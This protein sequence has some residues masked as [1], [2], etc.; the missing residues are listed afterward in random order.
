MAFLEE[1]LLVWGRTQHLS[2]AHAR[3]LYI[4]IQ[5]SCSVIKLLF[6]F[7]VQ[8]DNKNVLFWQT[9]FVNQT[10]MKEKDEVSQLLSKLSLKN[11]LDQEDEEEEV[12]ESLVV[13]ENDEEKADFNYTSKAP[14]R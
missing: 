2:S 5:F 13:V 7:K 3:C 4:F 8:V 14:I 9:H 11:N 12:V 10:I 6:A 1:L